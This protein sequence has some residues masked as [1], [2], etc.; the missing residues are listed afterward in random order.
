MGFFSLWKK[1]KLNEPTPTDK[2]ADELTQQFHKNA[3]DGRV[4]IKQVNK[5]LSNG[6][7]VKIYKASHVR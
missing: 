6:V 1:Q 2:K 5:V 4:Y 7:I 3:D